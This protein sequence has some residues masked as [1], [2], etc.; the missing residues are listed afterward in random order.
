MAI[1]WDHFLTDVRA[2]SPVGIFH[3]FDNNVQ[4]IIINTEKS[5]ESTYSMVDAGNYDESFID[6]SVV[7]R[8]GLTHFTARH[9]WNGEIWA[10]GITS[11]RVPATST[12]PAIEVG[13]YLYRYSY[14]K[15]I[16]T[17]VKAI[18]TKEQSDSQTRDCSV[19]IVNITEDNY[20]RYSSIFAPGARIIVKVGMGDSEKMTLTSIYIDQIPWSKIGDTVKLTGRNAIGYY[21][22]DQTFD[23]KRIY[24]GKL[25]DVLTQIFE[26]I[27]FD[28]RKLDIMY[29]AEEVDIEFD[30]SSDI[31]KGVKNLLDLYSFEIIELPNNKIVIGDKAYVERHMK[32]MNHNIE[33]DAV[34]AREIT[35]SADG[36]YRRICLTS[37]YE[38]APGSWSSRYSYHDVDTFDNWSVGPHKTLYINVANGLTALRLY[39]LGTQYK[40]MYR[41][42]G[43]QVSLET[44]IRPHLQSGDV[45][46]L[47]DAELH[48]Y[49]SSAVI[50]SVN[51]MINM[52]SGTA[53]T[54]IT[55]DSGGTITI[56][57]DDTVETITPFKTYG[58]T[59]QPTLIDIFKK[60]NTEI[61]RADVE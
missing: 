3:Y 59:R 40:K 22:S 5:L 24:T 17:I 33:K 13:F 45:A 56:H 47:L 60:V 18:D 57:D 38:V 46:T 9:D 53:H 19:E 42:M 7:G 28:M 48:E 15:D 29:S 44:P 20:N 8:F 21:L 61:R 41:L 14:Y 58:D 32:F 31:M 35:Q 36:A 10:V 26:N 27:E 54:V 25:S 37:N 30:S 50:T 55:M 6:S 1:A 4:N 52:D 2:G 23:D 43:I 12:T 34:F 11:E 49:V 16:S 51:H 39:T